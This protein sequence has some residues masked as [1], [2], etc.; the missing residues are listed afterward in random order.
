MNCALFI[1]HVTYYINKHKRI[2]FKRSFTWVIIC[3]LTSSLILTLV[4]VPTV[5]YL[6]DRLKEKIIKRKS[7]HVAVVTAAPDFTVEI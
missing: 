5:Y 4:V 6:F 2:F 7:K 3:D 1:K